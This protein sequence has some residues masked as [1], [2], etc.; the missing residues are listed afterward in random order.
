MRQTLRRHTLRLRRRLTI[1]GMRRTWYEASAEL[2]SQS[3]QMG[4]PCAQLGCIRCERWAEARPREVR[5]MMSS[6]LMSTNLSRAP[7]RVQHLRD[8]RGVGLLGNIWRMRYREVLHKRSI[9]AMHIQDM[10]GTVAQTSD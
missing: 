8:L 7:L 3:S 9:V 1:Y 10:S 4:A 6:L 2:R 5:G